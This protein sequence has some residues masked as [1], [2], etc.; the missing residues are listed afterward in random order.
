MGLFLNGIALVCLGGDDLGMA[1]GRVPRL[2]IAQRGQKK[3]RPW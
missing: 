3:S 2:S 1:L